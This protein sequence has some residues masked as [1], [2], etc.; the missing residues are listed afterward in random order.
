MNGTDRQQRIS[1]PLRL[2]SWILFPGHRLTQVHIYSNIDPI[3]VI[4][5]V[6][7]S[8]N[9]LFGKAILCRGLN[10]GQKIDEAPNAVTQHCW[11]SGT[12]TS[13][14]FFLTNSDKRLKDTPCVS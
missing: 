4:R 8:L 9:E 1:T 2:H 6:S 14:D 3:N 7:F 10:D 12:Y 11:V 13:T 5:I